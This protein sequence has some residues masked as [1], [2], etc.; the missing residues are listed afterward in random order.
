[1]VSQTPAAPLRKWGKIIYTYVYYIL[2][3]LSTEKCIV[4]HYELK[5]NSWNLHFVISRMLSGSG[6]FLVFSQRYVILK[7]D[8]R[9][10]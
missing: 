10:A 4:A 1:M 7:K 3:V 2:N 8:S 5:V 9:Q 6:I